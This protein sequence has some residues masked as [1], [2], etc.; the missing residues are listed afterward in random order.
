MEALY[1]TVRSFSSQTASFYPELQPSRKAVGLIAASQFEIA[2]PKALSD[3]LVYLQTMILMAIE[4]GNQGPTNTRST[5]GP[6]QSVWL[7]SAVGLAYSLKLHIPKQ[8]DKISDGDRD[9]D[10]NLAR[11]V[12]WSLVILDRFHASGTSSPVMI[13]DTS[14]VLLPEDHHLFGEAT[15][16][17]ARKLTNPLLT[18]VMLT[19]QAL[20]SFMDTWRLSPSLHLISHLLDPQP[21]Q[22][23]ALF[24]LAN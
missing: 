7:G 4:A 23:L 9:S 2:A 15:Y 1:A 6:S 20:H 21:H 16:H 10:E 17:L 19:L 8:G 14:V 5:S 11:R 18:G 12:W 13:P 3:N 22:S 24:S